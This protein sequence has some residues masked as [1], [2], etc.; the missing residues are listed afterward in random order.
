[1]FHSYEQSNGQSASEDGQ[2][3]NIGAENEAIE[4]HGQYK[5]VDPET[6]QEFVVNYIA[7][8]NGFQPEGAHLPKAA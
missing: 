8:E 4:V 3:K 6:N 5:Y 7:N 2:L 1:M